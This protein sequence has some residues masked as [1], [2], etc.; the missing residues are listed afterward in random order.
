M[1]LF[2]RM[3]LPPE[4]PPLMYDHSRLPFCSDTRCGRLYVLWRNARHHCRDP[5]GSF[6]GVSWLSPACLV[7][8]AC[9]GHIDRGRVSRPVLWQHSP[10]S[11]D[12]GIS[13]QRRVNARGN[14]RQRVTR[15]E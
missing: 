5:S 12:E 1:L 6:R 2:Q 7:C 14:C 11:A 15:L 10:R 13:P 8:D 4:H 3:V 9:V